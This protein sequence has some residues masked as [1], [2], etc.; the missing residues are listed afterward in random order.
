MLGENGNAFDKIWN[1][2]RNDIYTTF[3]NSV[4]S[5]LNGNSYQIYKYEVLHRRMFNKQLYDHMSDDQSKNS[6][7]Q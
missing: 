5:I 4:T 6:S 1:D 7:R 3:R 2:V